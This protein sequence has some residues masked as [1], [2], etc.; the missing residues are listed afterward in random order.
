[1]FRLAA[2]FALAAAPAAATTCDEYV[3]MMRN[4][5]VRTLVETGCVQRADVPAL[6]PNWNFILESPAGA[7]LASRWVQGDEKV[8]GMMVYFKMMNEQKDAQGCPA[9][10]HPNRP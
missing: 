7:C 9:T 4:E 6:H 10:E 2:A 8:M 5:G 1:M 3:A